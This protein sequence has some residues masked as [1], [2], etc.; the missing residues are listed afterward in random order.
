MYHGPI[1]TKEGEQCTTDKDLDLAMLATRE[2][3]FES[4][5][6]ADRA[7]DPV[8]NAYHNCEPWL[9]IPVPP[10][11]AFY[12]TLLHTKD[13]APGPDGIPYSAWRLLPDV[14]VDTL[15]SYFYDIVNGTALPP[16][17]VGVWIPKAKSGPTADHFRPLG[18][19]NTIDRLIDGAIASH[20]MSLTA[21]LLH[22][23]QAVMSCFKE[24]QKAV[25]AIQ[26]ILDGTCPACALLADLS[27]AFERVNPYWILEL[28]RIRQAPRWLVAYTKFILFN[29]RVTHKVQGTLLP[30]RV[31][32]QGVDMGRSFSVYLF[33]LAMDPL[34]VY[35]NRIP[36]VITVQGYV[37][38]TT[39]IGNAQDPDWLTTV[40]DC[41]LDLATAGF[42]MDQHSCFRG[43]ITTHNKFPPR[44]C[45]AAFSNANWP[46]LG[47]SVPQSTLSGVLRSLCRPGYNVAVLREGVFPNEEN[48][49]DAFEQGSSIICVVSYQQAQDF[50]GGKT[51]HMLGAFAKGKCSC[52][53]KTHVLTNFR[54]RPHGIACLEKTGFGLQSLVGK[55][56]ALGLALAGRWVFDCSGGYQEYQLSNGIEESVAT[57]FKKPHERLKSFQQPTLSIVSRCIGFNTFILSVMPYTMSFFGLNTQELNRLRQTAVGFI[58]KRHWIAAEI[59][60]YVLRY[61]K[62]APMLD[63]GLSAL[64]AAL[65]LYLREGNSVEELTSEVQHANCN[66]RQLSVVKE[67]IEMWAPFVSIAE[68]FEA[69]SRP[70]KSCH[71]KLLAE[72]VVIMAMVREAK[73]QLRIK[74]TREGWSGGIS[75]QW[76]EVV[77]GLKKTWCN[78]ISRYTL[79]RWAVNQDDDVWLSMRGTRRQQLCGHCQQQADS[80]PYGFYHPPFCETC[81]RES[82]TTVWTLST[83]HLRLFHSYLAMADGQQAADLDGSLPVQA[84]NDCVCRACGCGDNTIGHWTRWCPIPLIVAHAILRPSYQHSTLNSIALITPRNTA[85]CTLILASF[86]RLLRQE[87]AFLH[88]N[89]ADAKNSSWWV[90]QL[91]LEVAKDAHFESNVP[92]PIQP[93][94]HPVCTVDTSK[95][96]LQ[97]VLPLTYNTLHTPPLVTVVTTNIQAGEQVAM[98]PLD[99][100]FTASLNIHSLTSP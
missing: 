68:I 4:P 16:M 26:T 77:A 86:R 13:S 11:S 12:S 3:W 96:D 53:S 30:S 35:L 6:D 85:I 32:L 95:L 18:M 54:M 72:N 28:L 99:S 69:V 90:Q 82:G 88:R 5:L 14:T 78:P 33:C 52:K 55:A 27:K 94:S 62:I 21:H 47:D 67:L 80:F 83:H 25:T 19:P 1:L 73:A 22:P 61:L 57:P 63:P 15:L 98:L 9:D 70:A 24:P 79:I 29:R 74:V 66:R 97:R 84:T 91:H 10:N 2:F 37:D 81:I 46:S 41:Y 56:P 7:W 38:D 44:C 20:V 40:A 71:A 65:G 34:F 89:K 45:S 42:V 36:G 75:F 8:L 43:C 92:F 58:L 76:V 23:S 31:I 64:V 50:L 48:S 59:L 51:L 60:P 17:Q 49:P 93:S 39:I 100:L 87:G